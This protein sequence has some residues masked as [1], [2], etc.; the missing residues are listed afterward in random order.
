MNDWV[1]LFCLQYMTA[2]AAAA[3]MQGTY[4]P[5]YTAV[6]PSAISVEVRHTSFFIHCEI[7]W[8]FTDDLSKRKLIL[9]SLTFIQVGPSLQVEP[10]IHGYGHEEVLESTPD[11]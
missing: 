6:P 7:R 3:P 10:L 8:H 11:F 2:A 5:Q 1:W 4:I 9:I